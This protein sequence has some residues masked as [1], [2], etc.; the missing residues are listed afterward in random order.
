MLAEALDG[1]RYVRFLEE[2][3]VVLAWHG[4]RGVHVYDAETGEELD[5]FNVGD[6]SK[7]EAT[8]EEV[9]RGIDRHVCYLSDG[10]A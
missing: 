7:D 4:G 8:I 3:G 6:F 5:M 9:E 10:E 1:A 2:L